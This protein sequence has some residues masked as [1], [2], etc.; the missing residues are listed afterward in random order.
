M[1][2]L[3]D[4][5]VF[6]SPV[7][8]AYVGLVLVCWLIPRMLLGWKRRHLRHHRAMVVLVTVATLIVDCAAFGVHERLARQRLTEVAD[9][10]T[11]YKARHGTY[12][13]ELQVLVPDFLP[14]MSSAKPLLMNGGITYLYED[15]APVLMYV[16]FGF[17]RPILD[18]TTRQWSVI[19]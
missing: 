3:L 5:G 1:F 15:D 6:G 18:V 11:R 4:A 9:A 10:L 7:L 19:D 2:L 13:R 16:S 8:G 12:P 17:F 14:E